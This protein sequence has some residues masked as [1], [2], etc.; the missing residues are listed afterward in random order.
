[1]KDMIKR[2]REEREGFTLAELLI[3]VA[4]IAVLV[5]IA[6]PV[7]NSQLEKS[8][9][10]VT[11]ANLRT[12]YAEAQTA[13]L[14]GSNSGNATYN[15]SK[16]GRT[17]TVTVKGVVAKGQSDGFSGLEA[18]LPFKGAMGNKCDAM[19]GT[20]GTYTVTFAYGASGAIT[21]VAAT[22]QK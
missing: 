1:M 13:Y 7:F 21:I 2:I 14:T 17:A 9:D 19:G 22:Q 8:R 18:E 20:A 16:D 11:V 10:A 15:K 3:V 12:A 5:A 4:I 6:I